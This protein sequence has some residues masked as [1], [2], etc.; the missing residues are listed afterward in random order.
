MKKVLLPLL[1]GGVD[2]T[3]ATLKAIQEENGNSVSRVVPVFIDYGQKSGKHEW[4]AVLRVSE[5]LKM[6]STAKG[7]K[8][9]PP[10]KI[11]LTSSKT[12]QGL[13]IFEW[14]QSML[15]KGGK[16]E[17]SEVE[18]RNMVLIAIIASYAKSMLT[19]NEKGIIVAGFRNEFYDTRIE[20]VKQINEVFKSLK[21]PVAVNTPIIEYEGVVGK[22]KLV[23]R[24]KS[25]GYGDL[26]DMT[27]SC[28]VPRNKDP[29]EECPAC[30][31]REKALPHA[32]SE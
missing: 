24:F 25:R 31:N 22:K 18:N 2:S 9:M 16:S 28:Y 14:S 32:Q 4:E 13:K 30:R 29:C 12:A 15:I 1:S 3:L 17:V 8:C 26:I 5:R 10:I 7:I 20:F 6:E 27:W 19:P 11:R 21:M 23:D